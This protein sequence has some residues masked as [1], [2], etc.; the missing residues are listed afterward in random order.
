MLP[1]NLH[2]CHQ[3]RASRHVIFSARAADRGVSLPACGCTLKIPGGRRRAAHPSRSRYPP[4]RPVILT[5]SS[6]TLSE[7]PEKA[8]ACLPGKEQACSAG[9]RL[10]TVHEACAQA[11]RLS[12]QWTRRHGAWG[13]ERLGHGLSVQRPHR[14]ACAAPRAGVNHWRSSLR[15]RT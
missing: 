7:Q 3:T 13:A 6:L 15:P 2:V 1:D 10:G 11:V 4:A 14:S 5:L 9:E 12:E 8:H